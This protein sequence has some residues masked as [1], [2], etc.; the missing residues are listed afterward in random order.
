MYLDVVMAIEQGQLDKYSKQEIIEM[1]KKAFVVADETLKTSNSTPV[2]IGAMKM[3]LIFQS[4][5]NLN[6]ENR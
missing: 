4:Q 6:K 3:L 5:F 2:T 1:I